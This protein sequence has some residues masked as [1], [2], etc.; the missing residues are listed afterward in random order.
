MKGSLIETTSR[1]PCSMA[2]RRTIRPIRPRTLLA[3][4][5]APRPKSPCVNVKRHIAEPRRRGKLGLMASAKGK[6]YSPK[7]LI[8]TLTMIAS[9][10]GGVGEVKRE[11][12]RVME[13]EEERKRNGVLINDP[14]GGRGV[15]AGGGVNLGVGLSR[16]IEGGAGG[17]SD[18]SGWTLGGECV[19]VCGRV[20]VQCH[21][22]GC[23]SPSCLAGTR[24]VI[25][26]MWTLTALSSQARHRILTL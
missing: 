19:R 3:P 15:Q 10:G 24:R 21:A 4:C 11:R 12:V 14:G 7:P 16:R 13:K 26:R 6:G 25:T 1:S 9:F 20:G 23:V 2:L 18:R 5:R 8:P 17:G 22:P